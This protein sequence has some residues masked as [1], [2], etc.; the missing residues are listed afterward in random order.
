MAQDSTKSKRYHGGEGRGFGTFNTDNRDPRPEDLVQLFKFGKDW[1]EIRLVGDVWAY[2]MHWITIYTNEGREV[3]VPRP[4][5]DFDTKLGVFDETIP[6]PYRRIPNDVQTSVHFYANA[7]VRSVQDDE[8]K[9]KSKPVKQERKTGF[10]DKDSDTWTAIR[11]VRVPVSV[12]RELKSLVSINKHKNSKGKLEA[13]DLSHEEFGANVHIRY[14]A[15][16][17]GATK[18]SVQKGDHA[19][20]TKAEKD[21][22]L[23]DISNLMKPKSFDDAKKDAEELAERASPETESKKGRKDK[24]QFDDDADML[25]DVKPEKKAKKKQGKSGKPEKKGAVKT[26]KKQ[27]KTGKKR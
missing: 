1:E 19:P 9:K 20:L 16:A 26:G 12:A 27:G 11:V 10:K 8:P 24:E 22:L 6:D 13:F 2:A 23:W 7:I 14:D 25:S 15:E 18:Y 21:Y 17:P 3:R 5:L 4:A